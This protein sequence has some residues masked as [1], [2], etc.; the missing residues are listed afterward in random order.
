MKN[1]IAKKIQVIILG[2]CCSFVLISAVRMMWEV[3]KEIEGLVALGVFG[4]I[5]A[6]QLFLF[7]VLINLYIE[8][9]KNSFGRV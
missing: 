9:F 7:Y 5:L 6:F 3:A 8:E 1:S 4:L 2:V